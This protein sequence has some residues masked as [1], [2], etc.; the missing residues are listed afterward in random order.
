MAKRH[1][2]REGLQDRVVSRCRQSRTPLEFNDA[3]QHN[4]QSQGR[5]QNGRY[6]EFL[7]MPPRAFSYYDLNRSI[8][9]G[10]ARKK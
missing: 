5:P 10:Y 4:T 6:E 2:K 8:H 9:A 7:G 3:T 1:Q